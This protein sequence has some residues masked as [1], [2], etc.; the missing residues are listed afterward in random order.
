M[1][2]TPGRAGQKPPPLHS[3]NPLGNIGT[4]GRFQPPDWGTVLYHSVKYF[5]SPVRHLNVQTVTRSTIQITKA[6]LTPIQPIIKANVI[7]EIIS[8]SKT[9]IPVQIFP[10]IEVNYLLQ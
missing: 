3:Q 10:E 4:K 2:V 1:I 9:T 8:S 7:N 6:M 5:L